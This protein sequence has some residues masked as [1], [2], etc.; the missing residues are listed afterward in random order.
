MDNWVRARNIEFATYNASVNP[1]NGKQN[2]RKLKKPSDL[3]RLPTDEKEKPI[4]G[5]AAQDLLDS[6]TE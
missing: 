4:T 5:Q 1:M 2:F 6:I 3:Y